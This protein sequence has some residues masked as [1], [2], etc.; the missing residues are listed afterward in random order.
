MRRKRF[1]FSADV[2][3]RT[4]RYR[5]AACGKSGEPGAMLGW[6]ARDLIGELREQALEISKSVRGD[7]EG[8]TVAPTMVLCS[9]DCEHNAQGWGW[10]GLPKPKGKRKQTTEEMLEQLLATVKPLA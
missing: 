10:I 5:C 2:M 4:P 1:Q 3:A 8:S 7:W 9:A 6:R